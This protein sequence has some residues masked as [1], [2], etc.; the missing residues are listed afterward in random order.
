MLGNNQKSRI[1]YIVT[2]LILS[3]IDINCQI[4]DY[5]ISGFIND[6]ISGEA[7]IGVNILV[8][9]DSINPKSDFFYGTSSNNFGFYILSNLP[10][11]NYFVI[12]S[13]M[14]HKT[15]IKEF[16]LKENENYFDENVLLHPVTYSLEEIII[17][18]KKNR[19]KTNSEIEISPELLKNLP[20]F[21]GEID[22]FRALQ[23]LPGVNKA[24]E[25]SNGLYLRGGPLDQTLTLVDGAIVYN[26]SHIGNIASTFNSDAIRD[27]KLIKGAFPSEYGGRLGGVLDIKLKSG[28]KEKEKQ[29]IGLSLINSFLSFEGPV[30][31]TSSYIFSGRWM[32]YDVIQ[33][34]FFQNSL[35]PLYRFYDGSGKIMHNFSKSSILTISGMFSY[36]KLYS[37]QNEDVA[38]DIEWK[39]MNLTLNWF[40]INSNS[41]FMNSTIS[42]INYEF[43]SKIGIGNSSTS[44]SSYFSNPDISSLTFKQ[45]A[46]I[47]IN[48]NNKLKTGM[49]ISVHNYNLMYNEYFN[50]Q[51]R[52]NEFY[53]NEL[54]NI[55]GAVY[56]QNEA[57]YFKNFRTNI[58][59]RVYYYIERNYLTF[60][61]R[62]S[63]SYELQR[64]FYLKGSYAAVDQNL[65]LISRNDIGL[66]TDLW[67][68]ATKNI[69]QEKS[70]QIVFG[71]DNYLDN[72]SFQLSFEAYYRDMQNLYEFIQSPS[73][74]SLNKNIENEFTSGQGEAYGAEIFFQKRAGNITGWVGY[75]LSW[76][77]RKFEELNFG[78][79]F[80]PK[81]DRRHDLSAVMNYEL[82]GEINIGAS[83]VYATGLRYSLP[84]SQFIFD[85]IGVPGNSQIYLSYGKMNESFFPPYHKLDLSMNYKMITDKAVLNFFVNLLNVYNRK[86]TYSQFV[87]I[88]KNSDGS[89][90]TQVKRI[91]LFPFIPSIGLSINF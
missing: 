26:P 9:K 60:E 37:P 53:S 56:F 18:G 71:F 28:T 48:V 77:K 2:L 25:L 52:N 58:G 15:L 8:Y 65:H 30:K 88:S 21:T 79:V 19:I 59:I 38:Y 10:A 35:V 44:S 47:N 1:I 31:E 40:K 87:I 90:K 36:D 69:S 17:E 33:K 64:N 43:S 78:E 29:T 82:T 72:G 12:Y 11:G 80:Y 45:N 34:N 75:T 76:S 54:N 73:I 55:E 89:E 84:P 3:A 20:S 39:N 68:P 13:Y 27:I 61:P 57:E 67:Y 62:V 16:S 63:Y 70:E 41:L 85:P 66:P 74:S 24:S 51:F 4:R 7:L 81:Y 83:F 91:S 42:F 23:M 6:S 32:Y 14:G 5:S 46:D 22:L 50:E 86:N 49:E